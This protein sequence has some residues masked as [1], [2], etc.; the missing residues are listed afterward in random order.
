MLRAYEHNQK[1]IAMGIAA[2]RTWTYHPTLSHSQIKRVMRKVC[3]ERTRCHAPTN[4]TKAISPQAWLPYVHGH[5]NHSQAIHGAVYTQE[6]SGAG[7]FWINEMR[8]AHEHTQSYLARGIVSERTNTTQ[9]ILPEAWL[10]TVRYNRHY[11]DRG[12]AAN[13]ATAS[14]PFAAT[15]KQ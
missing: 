5:I 14:S 10:P 8:R 13:L 9:A 15:T 7:S 12:M 1:Y 6:G 2:M 11:L 3:S 4:I